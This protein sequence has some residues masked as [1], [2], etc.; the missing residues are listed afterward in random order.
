LKDIHWRENSG[1]DGLHFLN[2]KKF[3]FFTGILNPWYF[4]DFSD[5]DVFP[6]L[7]IVSD[8]FSHRITSH[9]F[10]IFQSEQLCFRTGNTREGD[11]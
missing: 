10:W 7:L 6:V 11:A 2:I 8:D 5:L 9:S 1:I 4:R 3:I